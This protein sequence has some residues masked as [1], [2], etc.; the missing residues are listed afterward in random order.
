MLMIIWRALVGLVIAGV[1]LTWLQ[2]RYGGSRRA[3]STDGLT[4]PMV[5]MPAVSTSGFEQQQ[6]Q[7]LPISVHQADKPVLSPLWRRWLDLAYWFFNPLVTRPVSRFLVGVVALLLML[8]LG[9]EFSPR[10]LAGFGPLAR[11]P[12]WMI[13][14]QM[15]VLVDFCGYWTHRAFHG[16]RLWAFHAVHHSPTQLDWLSAARIHPVNELLGSLAPALLV[17]ALGYPATGLAAVT[18]FLGL[19]GLLLHTDVPWDFGRLR[20]VIASPAFHR[21]HHS[22]EPQAMGKNLAGFLPVWD[23]LFGTLYLPKGRQ[24]RVFGVQEELPVTLWGQLLYPWRNAQQRRVVPHPASGE[25]KG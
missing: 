7:Q 23:W 22:C 1:V 3:Q 9:R 8:L 13:G 5:V 25:A 24:P 16:R 6:Q 20:Y 11:Q 17:V 14:L 10:A 4:R 18:P 15:L 2:R 21:W 19:Y 12:A